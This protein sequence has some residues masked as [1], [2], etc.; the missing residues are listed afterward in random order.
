MLSHGENRHR[1]FRDSFGV[2]QESG[3]HCTSN[4]AGQ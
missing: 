3:F 2:M 4:L 1:H